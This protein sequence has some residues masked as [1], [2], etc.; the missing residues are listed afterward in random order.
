MTSGF[1]QLKST[2]PTN[3]FLYETDKIIISSLKNDT[4]LQS[5]HLY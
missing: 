3:I 1:L 2:I 4:K 5:C